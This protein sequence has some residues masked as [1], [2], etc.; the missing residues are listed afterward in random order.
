MGGGCDGNPEILCTEDLHPPAIAN[1]IFP[2][3]WNSTTEILLPSFRKLWPLQYM[4]FFKFLPHSLASAVM[5]GIIQ[6]EPE[7]VYMRSALH[8]AHLSLQSAQAIPHTITQEDIRS[9]LGGEAEEEEEEDQAWKPRVI[10]T[11]VL[12]W[13]TLI[14]PRQKCAWNFM[15]L[16]EIWKLVK[17]WVNFS[18]KF[19]EFHEDSWC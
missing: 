16:L 5:T 4:F 15:K 6:N 12:W 14:S 10:A 11:G 19:T 13:Q 7:H 9:P 1:H 3:Q 18:W 8:A 2:P 17:F